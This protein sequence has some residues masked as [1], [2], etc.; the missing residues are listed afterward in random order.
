[1]NTRTLLPL[2][3]LLSLTAAC[4]SAGSF[5]G[6]LVDGMTGQP[7]ADLVVLGK[8]P[9]SGDMACQIV[10]GKT[11]ANGVFSF[12]KT[13]KGASYSIEVKDKTLLLADAPK[14]EG[15]VKSTGPVEIK[16][17]RAPAGDGISTLKDDKLGNVA[18]RSVLKRDE[19][20]KGT[21]TVALFTK[22]KFKTPTTVD[23]G[24]FLVISGKDLNGKVKIE[25]IVPAPGV[26]TFDS[27][28]TLE[29][30]VFVGLR[31]AADGLAAEPVAVQLDAAVVK[32]LT[33]GDSVV[34]YIPTN[35]LPNGQYVIYSEGDK[36][37]L[38][39]QMGKSEA[40]GTAAAP[41]AG[42]GAPPAATP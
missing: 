27:G 29:N 38:V 8:A 24:S 40:A 37:A 39:V 15:G 28:N 34:R 17:W 31:F 12:P 11:D 33:V 25:P 18:S 32:T 26:V 7:R 14:V 36:E 41:P 9:D 6:K 19:K 10:E 4:S 16:A 2:L 23:D 35:A 1:M 42:A 22:E 21:Q 3:S 5:E 20:V 30:H 13:C